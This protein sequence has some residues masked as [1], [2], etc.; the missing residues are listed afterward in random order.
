MDELDVDMLKVL[1]RFPLEDLSN[2]DFTVHAMRKALGAKSVASIITPEHVAIY[3]RT[4]EAFLQACINT[5]Q[6]VSPDRPGY[7]TFELDHVVLGNMDRAEEL[8][9]IIKDRNVTDENTLT[10][11]LDGMRDNHSALR[12][13]AL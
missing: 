11:L 7:T 10:G 6:H 8:I 5:G 9:Q 2:V 3:K 1:E 13:G 4:Q 12:E